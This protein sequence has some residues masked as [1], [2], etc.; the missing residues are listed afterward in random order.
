MNIRPAASLAVM[1]SRFLAG[2]WRAEL[3]TGLSLTPGTQT[4]EI[5]VSSRSAEV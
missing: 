1:L 2:E 3:S 4:G 5:T